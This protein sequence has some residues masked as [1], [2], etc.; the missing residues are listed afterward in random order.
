MRVAGFLAGGVTATGAVRASC[1]SERPEVVYYAD[2]V[3]LALHTVTRLGWA[4]H[5]ALA[6]RAFGWVLTRQRPDGGFPFSRGD[7]GVLE[8]R[9]AYPRYLATTLFHMAE[10]ARAAQASR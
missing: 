6:D 10:R 4:D 1:R 3:G 9:N 8:D 7:Y 5:G 2:T